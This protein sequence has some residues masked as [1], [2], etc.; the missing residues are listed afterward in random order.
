MPRPAPM[1]RHMARRTVEV[2]G[3]RELEQNL[4]KLSK[5][6]AKGATRRTLMKAAE[7]L[8]Q[9][10]QGKAPVLSGELKLGISKTAKKPKNYEAG[11]IAYNKTMRETANKQAAVAA[12]REARKQNPATFSEVFV[13]PL[14]RQFYA[15]FAEFGTEH[16]APKPYMR[17][18]WDEKQ[19]ECLDIIKAELGNEI[20]KSAARM[21]K[22]AAK[23]R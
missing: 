5:S 10:A 11:K 17:P 18:A 13:G 19:D 20:D 16:S 2:K 22:K 6:M 12:M 21:A 9:A 14:A 7:P 4:A 15:H 8:K 1:G 3:L 23:G